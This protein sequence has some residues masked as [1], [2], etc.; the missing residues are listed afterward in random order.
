MYLCSLNIRDYRKFRPSEHRIQMKLYST[1]NTQATVSLKEAVFKGLPPDNGLYMPTSIPQ[2]PKSFFDNIENLSFQE[3][4]FEVSKALIGN[5]IPEADLKQIIKDVITFDAPVVHLKD[6]LYVLE[7]FHGPSFAFKDFGARFMARLMS[8][9]LQKENKEIN[10]LVATSGDTGSAVAQGFLNMPGIKVTILYPSKKVSEIQEKQLTTLGQ[11]VTALEVN[12]NFDDCQRMVKE[13]FL[14]KELNEKLTLSSANSINISRLIPQ[15]FYYFYAYAQIKKLGKPVVFCTPSGNFGNLCGGLIG[16]RMGLP[17]QKF[18]AATNA[19]DI[20][21][22]YLWTGLF[23]PK[24][25]V[26]TISNA[27]DVGNPSNFARIQALFDSDLEKVKTEIVGKVYH[28]DATKA[29]MKTVYQETG[30]IMCPHTAVA[31]LGLK[32]Y[33]KETGSDATGIFLSTAHPAKFID[34]V[35][36]TIGKKIEIPAKLATVLQKEKISVNMSN[37]FIDFKQF[38]LA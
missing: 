7:L 21:P 3:I 37:N 9:F 20:V 16:K 34:I 35:E 8:Y 30:Y 14:D 17:V 33:L 13:A 6:N 1:K 36:E 31:Y 26:A 25:S 29:A 27:M 19:N 11:N 23:E 22:K 18:I 32:E 15:S 12:G 10:I 5:D 28:D 24:S 38:L 4:A 2:L